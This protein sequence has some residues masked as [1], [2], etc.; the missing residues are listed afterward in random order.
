MTVSAIYICPVNGVIDFRPPDPGRLHQAA[1]T[2]RDLGV[3]KFWFPVIEE[4]LMMPCRDMVRYLDGIIR[5][6]DIADEAGLT[7]GVMAPA[8][9]AAWMTRLDGSGVTM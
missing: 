1:G 3:E 2:A 9:N 6:L 7:A 5:S 4:T 8:R